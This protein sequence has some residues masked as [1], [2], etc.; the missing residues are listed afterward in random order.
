MAN[1]GA[2]PAAGG[3]N[4][5]M[6]VPNP[7]VQAPNPPPLNQQNQFFQSLVDRLDRSNNSSVKNIPIE[8]YRSG[9]DFDQ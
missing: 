2:N 3:A 5:A 8:V 1:N 9:Q 6:N 7:G 4:P